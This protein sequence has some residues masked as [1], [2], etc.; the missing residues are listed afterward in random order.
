MSDRLPVEL[1]LVI[2][3]DA[4]DI[5]VISDR[6]SAA[7]LAQTCRLAYDTVRPIL[8]RRVIATGSN[9][10]ALDYALR[11]GDNAPMIQDLSLTATAWGPS[12][13]A[14]RNLTNLRCLRGNP[15][16][17]RIAIDGIPASAHASLFKLQLWNH[18]ALRVVPPNVTHVSLCAK[19]IVGRVLQAFVA[20]VADTSSLTHFA[21]E[22]ISLEAASLWQD[23][24]GENLVDGLRVIFKAGGPRLV[25]IC[26]RL[27]GDIASESSD[28]WNGILDM[29]REAQASEGDAEWTNRLRIW[30]DTRRFVDYQDDID[31]SISDARAGVDVWSEARPLAEFL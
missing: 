24:V 18:Y 17:I 22:F 29:L 14:L 5:F 30:R 11:Q 13:P 26:V 2:F 7:A 27:A 4:A 19:K 25:E 16:S 20:W 1:A 3:R 10:L 6:P 21:L 8:L 23:I 31:T 9:S 15:E 28:N 12:R